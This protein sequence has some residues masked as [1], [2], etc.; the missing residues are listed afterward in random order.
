MYFK[1]RP[2]QACVF[3]LTALAAAQPLMGSDLRYGLGLE[4]GQVSLSTSEANEIDKDGQSF[5]AI[6]SVSTIR[7]AGIWA[8]GLGFSSANLEGDKSSRGVKQDLGLDL[9]LVDL[10][11]LYLLSES[12]AFGPSFRGS[13]GKGAKHGVEDNDDIDFMLS[14][15]LVLQYSWTQHELRPAL[16]LSYYRDVNI[17]HRDVSSFLLSV[18]IST[19]FTPETPEE[20]K[21]PA[22]PVVAEE[23][24]ALTEAEE[25]AREAASVAAAVA[26][27]PPP[28]L[29][30]AVPA[31]TPSPLKPIIL[32]IDP[33]SGKLTPDA[34]KE[35][36]TIAKVLKDSHENWSKLTVSGH[37]DRNGVPALNKQLSR[38][39]AEA[40]CESLSAQSI[41]RDKMS[42]VGLGSEQLLP[43]LPK[44][45]R[46]QRRVEILIEARDQQSAESMEVELAKALAK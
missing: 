35:L 15:G 8:L 27:P 31:E 33:N 29:V 38:Q 36:T 9:F 41:A 3:L 21:T 39:R 5:G 11:Y 26:A 19:S 7:N 17:S 34:L 23:A 40:V 32:A 22:P 2:S 24:K 20:S 16:G 13:Y 37:S 25:Q 30:P 18:S 14:P 42:C 44:K 46:A 43:N 4:A 10:R 12:L 6:A 1:Y 28:P 45:A